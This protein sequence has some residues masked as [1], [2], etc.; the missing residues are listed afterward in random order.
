MTRPEYTGL[1]YYTKIRRA[2]L[3]ACNKVLMSYPHL[4][5]NPKMEAPPER[6]NYGGEF[7]TIQNEEWKVQSTRKITKQKRL[8]KRDSITD[9]IETSNQFQAL[10]NE[11]LSKPGEETRNPLNKNK[12]PER[13]LPRGQ[14]QEPTREHSN[15]GRQESSQGQH[16]IVQT[17]GSPLLPTTPPPPNHNQA[18]PQFYENNSIHNDNNNIGDLFER[19]DTIGQLIDVPKIIRFFDELIVK[20]RN[21]SKNRRNETAILFLLNVIPAQESKS[22]LVE[23]NRKFHLESNTGKEPESDILEQKKG[24]VSP[25]TPEAYVDRMSDTPNDLSEMRTISSSPLTPSNSSLA[26]EGNSDNELADNS[27]NTTIRYRRYSVKSDT[28][29]DYGD[30]AVFKVPATPDAEKKEPATLETEKNSDEVLE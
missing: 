9:I 7:S 25:D 2:E 28:G 3:D 13:Q 30:D 20:L 27:L 4:K 19:F 26:D 18:E 6:D 21:T 12:G 22:E 23:S 8:L 1:N 5:E 16:R 29:M 11:E 24:D 14:G 10:S 17:V 15:H